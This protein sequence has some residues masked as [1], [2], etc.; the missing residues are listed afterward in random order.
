M[1][2]FAFKQ[3]GEAVATQM[4]SE[5]CRRLQH[6]YNIWIS[7]QEPNYRYTAEDLGSH[8]PA[9]EW[10]ELCASLDARGE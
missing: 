10:V 4:A 7:Q 1:S 5:W 6:F 9:A 8:I 2:S 3:F